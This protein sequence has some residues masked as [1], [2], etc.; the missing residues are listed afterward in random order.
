MYTLTLLWTVPDLNW[1]LKLAKLLCSPTIPTAHLFFEHHIRLELITSS[2][3]RKRSTLELVMQLAAT[4]YYF[5][6]YLLRYLAICSVDRTRTDIV[7]IPNE[8][9]QPLGYYA[10]L[11]DQRDS[12]PHHTAWQAGIV[13]HSTMILFITILQKTIKIRTPE[14]TWTFNSLI[15]SQVLYQL[16]Y[17]S[18]IWC[19]QR[20]SNPQRTYVY[21]TG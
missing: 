17:K 13:N 5:I 16:S 14:R 12:N 10:I 3:A 4:S 19:T 2:L 11:Q 15:K 9:P 18:I 6:R 20:D 21:P 8:V 7:F 1:W